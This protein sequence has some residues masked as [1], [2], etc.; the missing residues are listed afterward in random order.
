MEAAFAHILN[1]ISIILGVAF[2]IALTVF[3]LIWRNFGTGVIS[4]KRRKNS[5]SK[6]KAGNLRPLM[7]NTLEDFR[8]CV[9][10]K[11]DDIDLYA[12]ERGCRNFASILDEMGFGGRLMAKSTI[13]NLDKLQTSL[14]SFELLTGMPAGRSLRE[15]YRWEKK[16]KGL[17]QPGGIIGDPSA[18]MGVLWCR[19]G[20]RAPPS[21]ASPQPLA[22]T[23][24]ISRFTARACVRRP[25][26][27]GQLFRAVH[28][29]ARDERVR[30][31][32]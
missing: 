17:H 30:R 18:A 28:G 4:P 5:E 14:T 3:L 29:R 20:A 24:T 8:Y 21:Q 6:F 15:L 19:H 7:K 12:F 2:L 16:Q 31:A 9:L 26:K 32:V 27:L 22:P 23:R 10:T 13:D 25:A 11:D 1:T